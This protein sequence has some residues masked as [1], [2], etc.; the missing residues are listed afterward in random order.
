MYACPPILSV[1]EHEMSRNCSQKEDEAKW[2][3]SA[4]L[5]L[6]MTRVK[7]VVKREWQA[8][9][10]E[11]IDM[12]SRQQLCSKRRLHRTSLLLS[13]LLHQQKWKKSD[14][15]IQ[16]PQYC[17]FYPVFFLTLLY[18]SHE[19]VDSTCDLRHTS[20]NF[21]DEQ[22]SKDPHETRTLIQSDM[23]ATPAKSH[24]SIAGLSRL[25]RTQEHQ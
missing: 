19:Q 21:H 23:R 4:K 9:E 1:Q 2:P 25:N 5:F 6:A 18:C 8:L 15:Q 10:Q 12:S 14:S 24:E 7:N 20:W 16:S 3:P 17:Y 22:T 11:Q 13:L